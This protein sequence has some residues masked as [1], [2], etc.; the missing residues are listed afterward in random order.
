MLY[1]RAEFMQI[2]HYALF[3]YIKTGYMGMAQNPKQREYSLSVLTETVRKRTG[4]EWACYGFKQA[5]G[6]NRRLL[7]FQFSIFN[8][9]FACAVAC[10]V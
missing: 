2:P 4:V 8:F 5:D 7:V 10:A 6:M 3:G 1:P 9:Q